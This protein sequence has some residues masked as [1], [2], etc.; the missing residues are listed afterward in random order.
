[1]SNTIRLSEDGDILFNK[2][3]RL[4]WIIDDN[5]KLLQSIRLRLDTLKGELYYEDEY[6][7]PLLKGKV[8]KESLNE[9]FEDTLLGD[10]RIIAVDVIE[11]KDISTEK[12]KGIYQVSLEIFLNDGETIEI[13]IEV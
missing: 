4:E 1:M 12:A 9:Y 6:G 13:D 11:F 10:E 8:N 5:E 3:G 2:V 7:H